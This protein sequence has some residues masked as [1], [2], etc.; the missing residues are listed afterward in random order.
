MWKQMGLLNLWKEDRK[1][2]A[3]IVFEFYHD[4]YKQFIV[5]TEKGFDCEKIERLKERFLTCFEDKDSNDFYWILKS[6]NFKAVRFYVN[7]IVSF[8]LGKSCLLTSR[9]C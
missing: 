7:K 6:E 4:F 1:F 2:L 5:T 9:G 8:W 3:Y